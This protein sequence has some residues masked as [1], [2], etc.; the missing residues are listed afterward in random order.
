M[1]V[2]MYVRAYIGFNFIY[3]AI[4]WAEDDKYRC[5][6]L[7]ISTDVEFYMRSIECQY[8]TY[9]IVFVC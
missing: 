5:R 3:A 1:Y 6:N 4:Q 2:C 7:W 8:Y 9:I